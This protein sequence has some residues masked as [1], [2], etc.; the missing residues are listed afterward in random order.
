MKNPQ[1]LTDL[2][3]LQHV[4]HVKLELYQNTLLHTAGSWQSLEINSYDG[5]EISFADIDA[6]VRDNRRYLLEAF[7][8][9]KAWRSMVGALKVASQRQGGMFCRKTWHL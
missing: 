7:L 3:M 9:P 5:F 1:Q 8:R 2:A 6:F 4:P